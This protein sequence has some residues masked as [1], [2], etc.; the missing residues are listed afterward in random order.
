MVDFM[1]KCAGK[2]AFSTVFN[3]F[4]FSIERTH[5]YIH[6]TMCNPPF[7]GNG[8][9]AFHFF[10]L[11]CISDNARIDQLIH[12]A[13]FTLHNCDTAQNTDLRCRKTA[14]V[15][16]AHGFHHVVDQRQNTRCDGFYRAA[17]FTQCF[18]ALFE[19]GSFCHD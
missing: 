14:T 8:K 6:G 16:A 13:R 4:S 7:S 18:V 11:A 15:R 17:D 3:R 5:R 9:T 1:A 2:Q 10:L 19:N 12:L